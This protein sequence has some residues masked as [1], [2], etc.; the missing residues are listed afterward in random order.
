MLFVTIFTNPGGF[1][2]TEGPENVECLHKRK[3]RRVAECEHCHFVGR[4]TEE[5][6]SHQCAVCYLI[7][8]FI[9]QIGDFRIECNSRYLV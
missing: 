5:R 7:L 3:K 4:S 6:G 2:D 9:D 8:L 1:E